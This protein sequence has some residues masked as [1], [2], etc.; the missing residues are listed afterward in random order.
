[1][2]HTILKVYLGATTQYS[3]LNVAINIFVSEPC[4]TTVV[5]SQQI[6]AQPLEIILGGTNLNIVF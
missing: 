1:M 4:L 5:N 2:G 6:A 3:F